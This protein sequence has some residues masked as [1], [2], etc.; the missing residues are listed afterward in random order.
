M[1][2]FFVAAMAAS[3]SATPAAAA[4]FTF[5]QSGYADG[6][7][8]TGSF[9]GSDLNGDGK[10]SSFDN[11]VSAFSVLFGGNS[12]VAAFTLDQSSLTPIGHFVNG[13]VYD[14]DGRIDYSADGLQAGNTN[15]SAFVALGGD[16]QD[17]GFC[18]S[19][20]GCGFINYF[21]TDE[22]GDKIVVTSVPEPAAWLLMTAG[23]GL[24][25]VAM[26]RRGAQALT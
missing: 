3:L 13:L 16:V 21:G 19:H 9:A 24:V 10:I 15:N 2:H 17:A 25:G 22:S 1:R 11:E 23:L 8:L 12:Q 7:K 14:L 6:A 5:I 26:R 20:A 18:T 4:T